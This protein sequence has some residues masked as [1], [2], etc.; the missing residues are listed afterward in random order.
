MREIAPLWDLDAFLAWVHT[1]KL[2]GT[3]GVLAEEKIV[4]FISH[5]RAI[6]AV[7][8]Y[9]PYAVAIKLESYLSKILCSYQP[10]LSR[11]SAPFWRIYSRL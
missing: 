7:S 6:D 3:L 9:M 5:L 8:A 1:K 10:Q 11:D 2:K 4:E